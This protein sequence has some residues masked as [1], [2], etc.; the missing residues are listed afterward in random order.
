MAGMKVLELILLQ[1]YIIQPRI[2]RL[3]MLWV[4]CGWTCGAQSLQISQ[5]VPCQIGPVELDEPWW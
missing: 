4:V 1:E 3:G 2:W 5:Q